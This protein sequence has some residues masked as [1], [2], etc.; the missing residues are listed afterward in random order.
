MTLTL[1][2]RK[3]PCRKVAFLLRLGVVFFFFLVIF[4]L[5]TGRQTAR[6][7]T[8]Y[9]APS[10]SEPITDMQNCLV[11]HLVSTKLRCTQ[12]RLVVQSVVL[13]HW[14]GAQHRS[15]KPRRT[16]RQKVM[17]KSPL[18]ITADRWTLTQMGPIPWPRLLT[19]EVI[20]L[21]VQYNKFSNCRSLQVHGLTLF[22]YSIKTQLDLWLSK[23][24]IALYLTY[25]L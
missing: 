6:L 22:R 13:Y 25:L 24:I 11:H 14:G 20:I 12:P 3:N 8:S 18:C 15:H 21:V 5:V 2:P 19:W 4:F 10:L 23:N 1:G 17:H 9:Y 7:T 16:D